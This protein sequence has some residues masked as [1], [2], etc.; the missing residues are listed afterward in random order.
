MWSQPAFDIEPGVIV[1]LERPGGGAVA[2]PLKYD[3]Y[4]GPNVEGKVVAVLRDVPRSPNKDK[5]ATQC[6]RAAGSL[7]SKVQRAEKAK[8]AALV[9]VSDADTVKT[10]DDLLDFN[11]TAIGGSAG[12][13][14][15][16]HLKRS[17]LETMLKAGGAKELAT[18][19]A[20]I[21]KE[22]K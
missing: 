14:P 4:A 18:I 2:G 16:F 1:V 22:M 8:A 15:V 17:V 5:D 10:G 19:E 6:P 12:K 9:F 20:E 13:I 7:G 3:D 21:N 11:Y